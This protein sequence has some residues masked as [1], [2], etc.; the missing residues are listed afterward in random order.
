MA[1][2][3]IKSESKG[4]TTREGELFFQGKYGECLDLIRNTIPK[5]SDY[6]DRKENLAILGSQCLYEMG[7]GKEIQSFFETSYR[8]QLLLIPPKVFFVYINYLLH[9]NQYKKAIDLLKKFKL[10]G[11]PMS[12]DE[13]QQWVQ[14]IIYDGFINHRKYKKAIK[15]LKKQHR[16]DIKIKT[17]LMN[18]IKLKIK[19]DSSILNA[20]IDQDDS[21]IS[22]DS[23][24]DKF[25]ETKSITNNTNNNNNDEKVKENKDN[26]EEDEQDEDDRKLDMMKPTKQFPKSSSPTSSATSIVQNIIINIKENTTRKAVFKFVVI[27]IVIWII[28]K[29]GKRNKKLINEYISD[30]RKLLIMSVG[31]SRIALN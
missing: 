16:L 1:T 5:L 26:D 17:N 29:V 13:Y 14:L 3:S 19:Q 21:D 24:Y 30:F 27:V 11:K 18:D 8:R 28:Y 20:I 7:S 12:N 6:D 2:R 25:G 4:D 15:F 10:K 31:K 23:D 22:D 9:I